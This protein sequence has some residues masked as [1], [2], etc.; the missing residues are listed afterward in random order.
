MYGAD[1]SELVP[2]QVAALLKEKFTDVPRN[3]SGE[4]RSNESTGSDD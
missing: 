3:E 1:V 2:L 4:R